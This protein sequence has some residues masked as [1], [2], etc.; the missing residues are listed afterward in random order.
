MYFLTRI[1]DHAALLHVTFTPHN[2]VTTK[3]N[4]LLFYTHG[5][6]L[7]IK[8]S[9]PILSYPIVSYQSLVSTNPLE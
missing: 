3:P 4:R 8:N 1:H 6:I 9:Y 5:T 7:A 2:D